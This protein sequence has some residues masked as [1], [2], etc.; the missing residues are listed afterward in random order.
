MNFCCWE[1]IRSVTLCGRARFIKE[2][3]ALSNEETDLAK[4]YRAVTRLHWAA[5]IHKQIFVKNISML[6]N[7]LMIFGYME[8]RKVRVDWHH[9]RMLPLAGHSQNSPFSPWLLG[10]S[11]LKKAVLLSV[12][13]SRSLHK[14]Y[15]YSGFATFPLYLAIQLNYQALTGWHR[16]KQLITVPISI[17]KFDWIL[18]FEFPS[19]F[20]SECRDSVYSSIV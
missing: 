19:D 17:F 9:V 5:L 7:I 18:L 14:V 2:C 8:V 13:V 3:W 11:G 1:E 15:K 10:L 16:N 4:I 20:P 6:K 12:T